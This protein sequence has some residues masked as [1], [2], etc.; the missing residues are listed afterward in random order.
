MNAKLLANNRFLT[1]I[2][3]HQTKNFR[4]RAIPYG[5][6]SETAAASAMSLIGLAVLAATMFSVLVKFRIL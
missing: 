5:S 1:R 4:P 3:N 6:Y 2:A